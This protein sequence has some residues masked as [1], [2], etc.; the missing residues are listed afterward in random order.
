MGNS[1]SADAWVGVYSRDLDTEL[2]EA[3]RLSDQAAIEAALAAGA[4]VHARQPAESCSA[5]QDEI[6]AVCKAGQNKFPYEDYVIRDYGKIE[7]QTTKGWTPLH[8][9]AWH[10]YGVDPS[11]TNG[12][13]TI[14]Q[15]AYDG[16]P[17]L[18]GS[19]K[20]HWHDRRQRFGQGS[21]Q[22]CCKVLLDAGADR[23]AK[24]TAPVGADLGKL[25][26][27]Y[28][29]NCALY[30]VMRDDG[31]GYLDSKEYKQRK[32]NRSCFLGN[33]TLFPPLL[34]H[35][36]PPSGHGRGPHTHRVDGAGTPQLRHPP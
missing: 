17:C 36:A 8:L 24:I 7:G 35:P 1:S 15:H 34:I 23:N 32:V 27:T 13:G 6:R 21:I 29:N 12:K 9:A 3:A 25:S 5:Y 26:L 19:Q 10:P 14:G 33:P 18:D 4:N 11:D 16:Y 31:R 2:L 30:S 20:M 28:K 22:Q